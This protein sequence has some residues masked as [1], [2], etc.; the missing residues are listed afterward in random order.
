[1]LDPGRTALLVVDVQEKLT[2]LMWEREAMLTA[3]RQVVEGARAL[4]L[5]VV[6]CEQ[7]P[8][9]L[10][11]TVP[12][13]AEPLR[14]AGYEPIPK[15]TFSCLAHPPIRAA[16]EAT[17]ARDVL[18]LGIETHV[19]VYQTSRDLLA[20]QRGVEVV[21]DAVSSRTARN[22]EL[23]LTRIQQAGGRLTSAEM[24]LFELLGRAEGDAFKAISRLVK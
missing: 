12:E 4:G 23:G 19:C 6:W 16:L 21:A 13:L 1:M 7:Y 17:G 22:R 11:P 15:K 20:A 8:E 24:C 2:R 10:G 14:A 5:P 9:G 3:M 18:V